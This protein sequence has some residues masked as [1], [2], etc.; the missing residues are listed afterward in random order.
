[1]NI[2][3]ASKASGISAKMIRYYESIG[4][5]PSAVRTQSGYREYT[6]IDVHRLRFLRRARDLGFSFDKVRALLKLWGDR[7]RSS[8]DVKILAL[9]H[10]E[11]LQVQVRN[12]NH[13]IAALEHLA[14]ACE[15]NHR[16]ECPIIDDLTS[17]GPADKVGAA[18]ANRRRNGTGAVTRHGAP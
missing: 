3:Q 6:D 4:L 14:S 7:N 9:E 18:P 13:L 17:R 2:G 12:L 1:M 10:I 15:G 5:V 8:A 16:P 11:E